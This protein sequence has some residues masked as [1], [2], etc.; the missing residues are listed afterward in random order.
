MSKTRRLRDGAG[1]RGWL[2]GCGKALRGS[3]RLDWQTLASPPHNDS[4]LRYSHCLCSRS[5][6]ASSFPPHGLLLETSVILIFLHRR[7]SLF[8]CLSVCCIS[9]RALNLHWF[10]SWTLSQSSCCISFSIPPTHSP[11]LCLFPSS[12]PSFR[13]F[14]S[15]APSFRSQD[16][17]TFDFIFIHFLSLG[18]S[19]PAAQP[20]HFLSKQE[21]RDLEGFMR[22]EL[23]W[24]IL[25]LL[26]L[27]LSP[28][29][30]GQAA[31]LPATLRNLVPEMKLYVAICVI[32]LWLRA[33]VGGSIVVIEARS[34]FICNN[35]AVSWRGDRLC[36]NKWRVKKKKR[37]VLFSSV[38][39]NHQPSFPL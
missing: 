23:L 13:H 28:S 31:Q 6:T 38:R 37:T 3:Q 8:I 19:T 21:K 29:F 25:L 14:F 22:V 5:S 16:A 27:S 24:I 11:L 2:G 34:W 39:I 12:S 17:N 7:F 15:F 32:F 33:R 9:L 36:G 35:R 10:F 20:R 1:P 18:R 30:S 4:Q 26:P